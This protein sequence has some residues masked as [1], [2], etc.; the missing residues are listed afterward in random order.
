[1]AIINFEAVR[2]YYNATDD[3]TLLAELF[4]ILADMIDW[5]C[6]GTRYNIHLDPADGLL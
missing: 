6:R 1:M 4:P 3:D 5:H 2:A